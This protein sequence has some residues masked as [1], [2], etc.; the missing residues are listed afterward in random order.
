MDKGQY[1][2]SMLIPADFLAPGLISITVGIM[3][4]AGGLSKDNSQT[5]CS[6]S[7]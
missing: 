2:S 5:R 7:P 1:K 4:I 3:Q 6:H